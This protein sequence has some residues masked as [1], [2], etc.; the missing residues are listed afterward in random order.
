M[1]DSAAGWPCAPSLD[2]LRRGPGRARVGLP[3]EP[4][5]HG[6]PGRLPGG[7]CPAGVRATAWEEAGAT[8]AAGLKAARALRSEGSC[9][10]ST[11][12]TGRAPVAEGARAIPHALGGRSLCP[13]PWPVAFVAGAAAVG[14]PPVLWSCRHLPKVLPVPRRPLGG[15]R[16]AV[17]SCPCPLPPVR[18]PH[19]GRP[20]RS[21]PSEP[22]TLS[23]TRS[24]EV[25][26][27]RAAN[28]L[29]M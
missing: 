1:A 25:T 14:W 20:L 15:H 22:L 24:S 9:E 29:S 12:R 11:P 8:A 7:R 3:L 27:Q 28:G 19:H 21:A 26:Q 10:R 4:H 5:A 17:I 16:A 23:Q 2:P 13:V 6:R 18:R